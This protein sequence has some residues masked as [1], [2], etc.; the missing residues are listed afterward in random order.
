LVELEFNQAGKS[1]FGSV[2]S[3]NVGSQMSIYLAY[4]SA[5]KEGDTITDYGDSVQLVTTANINEA[6]YGNAT[7]TGNFDQETVENVYNLSGSPEINLLTDAISPYVLSGLTLSGTGENAETELFK[8]RTMNIET[9]EIDTVEQELP[10]SGTIKLDLGLEKNAGEIF[11]GKKIILKITVQGMQ[12]RNTNNNL[13]ED[14]FVNEFVV[15]E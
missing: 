2:T 11:E 6:I 9:G 14:L 12:F 10:S 1:Q 4:D 8:S 5:I 3:E 7:I 13:W 15:G